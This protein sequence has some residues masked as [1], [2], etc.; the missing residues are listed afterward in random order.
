MGELM[1]ATEDNPFGY[2]E[3][4]G[5]ADAH[6]DL[7]AQMERDW[8]CP[9]TTFEPGDFDL[10][11]LSEQ[12]DIHQR[13]P[14]V[15]AMKDPR[16]MFMLPAWSHLGVKTVRL[17]AVA[18]TPAGTIRS[19]ERRDG[20]R[21]DRAEAIVDAY[22]GR[23]LEIAEQTSLPIIQFPGLG[24]QLVKQ[25]SGLAA[26]LNLPWDASVAEDIF[27]Q[28]LVHFPT[29][30]Q[31]AS[32]AYERLI[33]A[34]EFPSRI[35]ATDLDSLD[36]TSAHPWPLET[37]LGVRHIQQ[38]NQLWE[39]AEF[40]TTENPQVVE[41]VLEGARAAR[42][43]R[44]GAEVRTIEVSGPMTVGATLLRDRL[45]PN[46]IVAHGLLSGQPDEDIEFFFRSL[47]MTT[48][49]LAEVWVD[50][51]TPTG[52]ALSS[53]KPSLPDNPRPQQVAAL[54]A[55]V[56]WDKVKTTRLSPGRSGMLLRKRVLTDSE[57][58]P[59][60]SDLIR[61]IQRVEDIEE[62]LA[63]IETFFGKTGITEHPTLERIGEYIHKSV[64]DSE[65]ARADTAE[66]NLTRLKNRRSVRF[67]LA[68]ARPFRPV[69][70]KIRS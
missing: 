7:L 6:R 5:V 22:L 21:Q 49:P 48:H 65:K 4:I 25:V 54:A 13:L 68:L 63:E 44:P 3:A 55:R 57:L 42:K 62:R 29:P 61:S 8:T 36:L 18:R 51:P 24:H 2:F 15:W 9:P 56:G 35:G 46:G 28:E 59:V 40:T 10:S 70:K 47:Y 50:V 32:P 34:A 1:P 41:V 27:A 64:F 33:G 17:I 67:A 69:F 20:I 30:L 12:V 52:R 38:R 58:V 26:S 16:S 53:V 14:G 60:V 45:R 11:G 37:H 23:L 19:I 66:R 43:N 39:I 31:D